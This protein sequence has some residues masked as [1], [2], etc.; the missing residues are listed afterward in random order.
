MRVLNCFMENRD[1]KEI[2]LDCASV[3]DPEAFHDILVETLVLPQWYGTNLDALY[4][5]LT[6]ITEQTEV[7]LLNFGQLGEQYAGF[8]TVF[9]D[10]ADANPRIRIEIV[11]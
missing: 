11:E 3:T 2:V 1:M 4:D 9:R 6:A 10:A 8:A 7:K 5:C